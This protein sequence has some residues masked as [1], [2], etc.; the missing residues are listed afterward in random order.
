VSLEAALEAS[1]A[2]IE[3]VLVADDSSPS[4]RAMRN[5]EFDRLAV[6]LAKLPR[7]SEPPWS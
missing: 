4:D 7:T 3:R 6:A 1:S 2:R 5:E